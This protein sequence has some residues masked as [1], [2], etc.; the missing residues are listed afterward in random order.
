MQQMQVLES[1]NLVSDLQPKAAQCYEMCL[2]FLISQNMHDLSCLYATT[3]NASFVNKIPY[4][5]GYWIQTMEI[6][7]DDQFNL[8]VVV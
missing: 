5:R 3:V 4:T 7:D 1:N 2:L 8:R 6:N